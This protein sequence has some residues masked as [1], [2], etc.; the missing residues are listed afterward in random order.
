MTNLPSFIITSIL[1]SF[2]GSQGQVFD[3]LQELSHTSRAYCRKHKEQIK[4]FVEKFTTHKLEPFGLKMPMSIDNNYDLEFF[5]WPEKIVQDP[6]LLRTMRLDEMKICFSNAGILTGLTI[7]L[8]DT[9][10]N[11]KVE[12]YDV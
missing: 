9:V 4:S 3:L 10:D 11:I 6:N 2:Y 1:L 12:K 8:W 5:E 7:S